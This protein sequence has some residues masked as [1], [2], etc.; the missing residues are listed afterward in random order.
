MP[1]NTER[2]LRSIPGGAA[3]AGVSAHTLR[4]RISAGDLPAYRFGPRL[5]RVDLNDI[6][7]MLR[8]TG[9]AA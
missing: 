2:R 7:A 6:D 9:G 5:I 1:E 8:P 3:Y 4:R